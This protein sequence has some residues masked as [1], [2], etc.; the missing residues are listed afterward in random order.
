MFER[1]RRIALS[2][3]VPNIRKVRQRFIYQ[4]PQARGQSTHGVHLTKSL[5]TEKEQQY[6]DTASDLRIARQFTHGPSTRRDL[7]HDDS[8]REQCEGVFSRRDSGWRWI[9]STARQRA[10]SDGIFSRRYSQRPRRGCRRIARDFS[11]H[12]RP[13]LV[14][15]SNRACGVAAKHRASVQRQSEGGTALSGVSEV[16]GSSGVRTMGPNK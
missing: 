12:L 10:D 13:I 3:R 2:G 16:L 4:C 1:K 15:T 8:E 14:L 6:S 9:L 5:L 7:S 11:V